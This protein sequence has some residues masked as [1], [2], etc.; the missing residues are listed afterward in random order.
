MKLILCFYF[1]QKY[2]NLNLKHSK[3]DVVLINQFIL[4]SFLKQW[5]DWQELIFWISELNC[6]WALSIKTRELVSNCGTIF[7]PKKENW[8]SCHFPWIFHL[9]QLES[10]HRKTAFYWNQRRGLWSVQSRKTTDLEDSKETRHGDVFFSPSLIYKKTFY[11]SKSLK[12]LQ[13]TKMG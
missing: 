13:I 2:S 3:G 1:T 10:W 8:G 9:A 6:V 11:N 5:H 4:C 12:Y 7:R